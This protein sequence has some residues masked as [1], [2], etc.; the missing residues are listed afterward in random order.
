MP[1]YMPTGGATLV[2][3]V[4][5]LELKKKPF[6][7]VPSGSGF[8][9]YVGVVLVLGLVGYELYR[10]AANSSAESKRSK[11]SREHPSKRTQQRNKRKQ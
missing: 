7:K 5:L 2:F 1:A 8:Y 6:I 10:R 4:E 3:S 9:G 11:K